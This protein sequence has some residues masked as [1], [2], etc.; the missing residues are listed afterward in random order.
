MEEETDIKKLRGGDR[1]RRQRYK[2]E[3]REGEKM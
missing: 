1:R 3:G 2:L